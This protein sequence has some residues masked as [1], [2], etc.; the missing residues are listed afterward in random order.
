MPQIPFSIAGCLFNPRE[1]RLKQ[2]CH[3][4]PGRKSYSSQ[5]GTGNNK[6]GRGGWGGV[7]ES[8]GIA[9]TRGRHT[10]ASPH[11]KTAADALFPRRLV[12]PSPLSSS[13][14]IGTT[15]EQGSPTRC[16]RSLRVAISDLD[17]TDPPPPPPPAEKN[18]ALSIPYKI[19]PSHYNTLLV[20]SNL[21][22]ARLATRHRQTSSSA[23]NAFKLFL[24]AGWLVCSPNK[25]A[26][27]ALGVH[28]HD[29]GSENDQKSSLKILKTCLPR[30][31]GAF[32]HRAAVTPRN[33]LSA[34]SSS[35]PT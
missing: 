11:S 25:K 13:P 4:F 32:V 5:D 20:V 22:I 10:G 35:Y 24:T 15:V 2:S 26:A 29:G 16:Y 8:S 34:R 17:P 23:P 9:E 3:F 7:N 21:P 31:R 19:E 28:M 1:S 6:N 12:L 14:K 30:F 27:R 18:N 33:K